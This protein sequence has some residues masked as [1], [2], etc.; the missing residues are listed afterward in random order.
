MT[1]PMQERTLHTADT[2]P[3][4]RCPSAMVARMDAIGRVRYRCPSC[5]RLAPERPRHPDDERYLR[6]PPAYSLPPIVDGQL[7]CQRC[8]TGVDKTAR[9]CLACQRLRRR[10]GQQTHQPG[11]WGEAKTRTCLG[12]GNVRQRFGGRTTSTACPNCKPTGTHGNRVYAARLCACGASFVP[13]GPNAKRCGA[14]R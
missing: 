1:A 14:C 4:S 9:F 6:R 2:V 11:R 7:R 10:E 12:C 5:D 13:T 8:A 3:C